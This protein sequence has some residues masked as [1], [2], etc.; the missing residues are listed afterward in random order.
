[1]FITAEYLP[2]VL[3]T[4]LDRDPRKKTD[5]KV[6]QVVSRLLGSPTIDLFV[7]HLCH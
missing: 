6:L 5:S 3:N 7:S 2:S 4:V 1:M